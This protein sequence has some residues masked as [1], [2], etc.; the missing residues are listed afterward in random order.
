MPVVDRNSFRGRELRGNANERGATSTHVVVKLPHGGAY[1]DGK[2]RC[3]IEATRGLTRADIEL[4]LCR[5]IKLDA[6]DNPWEFPATVMRNKR[7]VDVLYKYRPKLHLVA[8]TGRYMRTAANTIGAVTQ[9]K[10]T[11]RSERQSVNQATSVQHRD[12]VADVQY[13]ISAKQGPEGLEAKQRWL[14]EVIEYYHD[15]GFTSKLFFRH[16]S[17]ATIGG[18][19]HQDLKSA[20]DLLLCQRDFIALPEAPPAWTEQINEDIAFGMISLLE[21]ESLWGTRT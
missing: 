9:L 15:R 19:V 18:E 16:A 5:H 13:R 12:F 1:D 21:K 3:C 4:F 6:T 17:G 14:K 11:K 8:D 7:A 2:Y 10:F 20:T